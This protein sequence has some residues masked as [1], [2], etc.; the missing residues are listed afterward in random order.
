MN[1][2][3]F[4]KGLHSNIIFSDEERSDIMIESLTNDGANIKNAICIEEFSEIIRQISKQ[5][6]GKG[7]RNE[8]LKEV[9]DSYICLFTICK[10]Y[11]FSKETT[12]KAIDVKLA[13]EKKKLEEQYGR[14]NI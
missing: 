1:K 8:L 13:H 9:A 5:I 3:E 12:D 7:D 2:E 14:V 6:R 11:G 4:I 10:I